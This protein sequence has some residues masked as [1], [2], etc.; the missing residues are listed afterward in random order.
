WEEEIKTQLDS[1]SIILLLLSPD[2]LSS[3][4]CGNEMAIALKK[5]EDDAQAVT[6]IPIITRP[7][8]WEI[9]PN[10]K[11]IEAAIKS[12]I[13]STAPDRDELYVEIT[14]SLVELAQVKKQALQLARLQ[15]E[16]DAFWQQI[17]TINTITNY[18]KYL[19]TYPNGKYIKAANKG[20]QK[21]E[22]A[23]E[24]ARL[25]KLQEQ[26]DNFWNK[27]VAAKK[28]P[29]VADYQEY[30]DKYSNGKY[31]DEALKAIANINKAKLEAA[32][33]KDK[34]T[35]SSATRANTKVAYQDYL[36]TFPNGLHQEGARAAIQKLILLIPEYI[37]G[38]IHK[39]KIIKDFHIGKYP[40]TVEEYV[41]F[42]NCYGSDVVKAGEYKGQEMVEEY[43]WSL[44]KVGKEWQAQKGYE[45]HPMIC[46]SWYGANE[47]CEWLKAVTGENYT[48]PS[49]WYWEYAASG[50]R[51]SK[52]FK[53]AGSNDLDEVAWYRGNSSNSINM[54]GQKKPN[55]LG[56]YDMSG[57]VWEWC[58]E[59]WDNDKQRRMRRGGSW[60]YPDKACR[61]SARN[62]T[63]ASVR[64]ANTGFRIIRA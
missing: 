5:H 22:A 15:A 38:G 19:K 2:F 36:A 10:L 52:G 46:V 61:P 7:C 64:N 24:K 31:A 18:R 9:N 1:A 28:M 29:A 34:A 14:K 33:A 60:S 58:E 16:E 32:R 44:K 17:I 40:V 63:Y 55:E 59:V 11:R 53:Y 39:D 4:Y 26:E 54:V 41:L 56:L 57:N 6:V 3:D 27:T 21:I 62:Y 48:L 49:E 30:L 37:K 20:I 45:S 51:Q 23:Q 25:A 13:I 47:Y 12:K 35:W 50:G 8:L 42:L 43:R